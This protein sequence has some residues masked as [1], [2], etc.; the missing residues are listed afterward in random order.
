MNLLQKHKEFWRT[1]MAR[2]EHSDKKENSIKTPACRVCTLGTTI[3]VAMYNLYRN[4]ILMDLEIQIQELRSNIC[5]EIGEEIFPYA[6]DFS[7][8]SQKHYDDF[9]TTYPEHHAQLTRLLAQYQ[10][11]VQCPACSEG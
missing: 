10:Q 3:T 4:Y 1:Y 11:T 7:L 8:K 9:K 2:R 5:K 6:R